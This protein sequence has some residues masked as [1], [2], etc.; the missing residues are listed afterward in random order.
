[1]AIDQS[2]LDAFSRFLNNGNTADT[3]EDALNAFR[4]YQRE[5]EQLRE[6]LAKSDGDAGQPLDDDALKQ[7]VRERLTQHGIT[8]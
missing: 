5:T 4:A 2:E 6:H 3:L 1:M 8:D 7:R